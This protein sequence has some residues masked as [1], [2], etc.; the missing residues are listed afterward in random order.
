MTKKI[1]YSGVEDGVYVAGAFSEFMSRINSDSIARRSSEYGEIFLN[2][3]WKIKHTGL[4]VD[5]FYQSADDEGPV[6]LL[7][8]GRL[9]RITEFQSA[10]LK[11]NEK[12]KQKQQNEKKSN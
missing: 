9:E 10:V 6:T 1:I 7:V 4:R 3:A 5:F 2:R 11:E 12:L 8:T